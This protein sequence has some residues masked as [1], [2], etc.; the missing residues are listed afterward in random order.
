MH[1]LLR[2]TNRQAADPRYCGGGAVTARWA[3]RLALAGLFLVAFVA[4]AVLLPTLGL[5]LLDQLG[6]AIQ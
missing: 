4:A 5:W 6:R 2:R 3:R 1:R